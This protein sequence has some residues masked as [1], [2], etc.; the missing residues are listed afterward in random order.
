MNV[1]LPLVAAVF[2]D[3]EVILLSEVCT[4]VKL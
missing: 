1:Y 3:S 4:H 2:E